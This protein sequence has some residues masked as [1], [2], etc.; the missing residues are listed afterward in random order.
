[1][2]PELQVLWE[3]SKKRIQIAQ[4]KQLAQAAVPMSDDFGLLGSFAED[5]PEAHALAREILV[6]PQ[7]SQS[8]YISQARH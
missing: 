7:N 1:M 6:E 5:E 3:D 4:E 8:E 2:S